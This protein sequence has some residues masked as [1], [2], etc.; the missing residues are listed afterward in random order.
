M[1]KPDNLTSLHIKML[2]EIFGVRKES[3]KPNVAACLGLGYDIIHDEMKARNIFHFK[4]CLTDA[5][6]GIQVG[7]KRSG[8][9][10]MVF[11][12]GCGQ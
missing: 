8:S 12:R 11:L 1:S 5:G 2:N 10:L 4:G 6:F 9:E 3:R 7:Q